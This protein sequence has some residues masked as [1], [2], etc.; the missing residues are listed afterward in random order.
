VL[1]GPRLGLGGRGRASPRSADPRGA[2]R[3]FVG[4]RPAPGSGVAPRERAPAPSPDRL[5]PPFRPRPRG[6]RLL[7]AR[8]RAGSAP[9]PEGGRAQGTAPR[10]REARGRDSAAGQEINR[11]AL[12]PALRVV[13]GRGDG[14]GFHV[15]G[16][17]GRLKWR[18]NAG[19]HQLLSPGPK[20]PSFL[21]VR[22]SCRRA[23]GEAGAGYCACLWGCGLGL[24]IAVC[25][26]LLHYS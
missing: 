25:S 5:C 26:M 20:A 18:R 15:R 8:P 12:S 3:R 17:K 16:E 6:F 1:G 2:T 9:D 10:R 13:A 21:P 4:A 23:A 22:R 7:P 24:G 14:A 19:S 11:E